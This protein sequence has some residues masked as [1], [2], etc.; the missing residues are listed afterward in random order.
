MTSISAL[1]RRLLA[2]MTELDRPVETPQS[3]LSWSDLPT[4]HPCT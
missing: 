3:L 2:W 4:H 1:F